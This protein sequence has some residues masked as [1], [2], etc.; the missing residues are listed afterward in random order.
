MKASESRDLGI[1]PILRIGLRCAQDV[2]TT[3]YNLLTCA[4]PMGAS[5]CDEWK[6]R[7]SLGYT[8]GQ[9][10]EMQGKALDKVAKKDVKVMVSSGVAPC[11]GFSVPAACDDVL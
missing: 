6:R 2:R 4:Q 9:I 1:R 10:F 7:L 8:A 11:D 5:N 3:T